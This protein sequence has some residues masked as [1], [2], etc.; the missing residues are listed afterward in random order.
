MGWCIIKAFYLFGPIADLNKI[1]Y[2][3]YFILEY[4][5]KVVVS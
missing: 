4:I 3:F 1:T 5:A 2:Y